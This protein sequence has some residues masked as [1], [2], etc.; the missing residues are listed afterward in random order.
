MELPLPEPGKASEGAFGVSS[1]WG[2]GFGYLTFV[3]SVGHLN[4]AVSRRLTGGQEEFQ[5]V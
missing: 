5:E 2:P 1:G 3:M 4:Q